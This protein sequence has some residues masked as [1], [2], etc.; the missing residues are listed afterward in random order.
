MINAVGHAAR[1]P[2]SRRERFEFQR[3]DA[4]PGLENR[5]TR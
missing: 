4:Q 1:H 5:A 3:E 2:F